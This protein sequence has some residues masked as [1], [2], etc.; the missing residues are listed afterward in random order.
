MALKE[1]VVDAGAKAM[2]MSH[3][4]ILKASRGRVLATPFGMPGIELT[5][6]GRK[7]GLR[8]TTMLTAPIM[9]SEKVVLVA[10]KGGDD[11]DPEWFRNL[12]A[13]P[14]VEVKVI[15][16]GEVRRLRARVAGPDE[17]AAMWPSIVASYRGYAGYQRRTRRDIPVVVCE[18]T[19][20]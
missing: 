15:A 20:S 16:T 10:S 9:D 5:V 14:D 1:A 6:T 8:R 7:S 17:K 13:N 18:P 12:V 3:R 11:R 4:I 19:G 2:N